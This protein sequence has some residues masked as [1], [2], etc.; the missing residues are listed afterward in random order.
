M[1]Q[2]PFNRIPPLPKLHQIHLELFPLSVNKQVNKVTSDKVYPPIL[3]Q[4]E[5][6]FMNETRAASG[7]SFALNS[8][9]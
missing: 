3:L 2:M 8:Q 5:T 1:I 9:N 7:S 6:D 4:F